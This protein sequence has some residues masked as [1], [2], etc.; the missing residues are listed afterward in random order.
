MR[1]MRF[2]ER[3]AVDSYTASCRQFGSDS[4]TWKTDAVVSGEGDF[5]LMGDIPNSVRVD[6]IGLFQHHMG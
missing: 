4:Q 3:V 2:L 5:I 1:I 6:V